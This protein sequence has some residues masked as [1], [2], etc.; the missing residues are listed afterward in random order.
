MRRGRRFQDM[1]VAFIILELFG[2]GS[3]AFE[4]IV[5]GALLA[6][7]PSDSADKDDAT[8][9]IVR[10]VPTQRSMMAFIRVHPRSSAASER[11]SVP[12]STRCWPM[13]GES[14]TEQVRAL[15]DREGF[16][17]FRLA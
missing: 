11:R 2:E 1:Q 13:S 3:P 5:K 6:A 17:P 12:C 15:R 10:Q 9:R 16:G 14:W 8:R 4:Q 7:G